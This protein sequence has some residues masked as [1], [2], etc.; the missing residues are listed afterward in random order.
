MTIS[1]EWLK[2]SGNKRPTK[3]FW[4]KRQAAGTPRSFHGDHG[5]TGAVTVKEEHKSEE[6]HGKQVAVDEH[7]DDDLEVVLMGEGHRVEQQEE[8]LEVRAPATRPPP[9]P[10]P[11]APAE[12]LKQKVVVVEKQSSKKKQMVVVM[13][14]KGFD[15][16]G[17]EQQ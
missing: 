13:E 8:V 14:N 15:K 2:R 17:G 9:S 4:I 11:R 5:L 12:V 16:G 1:L 10:P 6:Q 3:P 7:S